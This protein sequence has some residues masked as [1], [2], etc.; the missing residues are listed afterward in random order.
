M[1]ALSI[2]FLVGVLLSSTLALFF[3][4]NMASQLK[5]VLSTEKR[6]YLI[7]LDLLRILR[8][9]NRLFPFSESMLGFWLSLIYFMISL[10]CMVY[11][12]VVR[13]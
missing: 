13:L 3:V 9:H 2:I 7:S 1:H 11:S 6:A 4:H 8:E 5:R 10:T 12:T